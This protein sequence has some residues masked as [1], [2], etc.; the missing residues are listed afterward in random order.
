V[1]ALV[2]LP[3]S[4]YGSVQFSEHLTKQ[5]RE[6]LPRENLRRVEMGEVSYIAHSL[7][8]FIDQYDQSIAKRIVDD[9]SD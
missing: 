2:G 6:R 4:L 1:E 5:I 8:F 3:Y 9:A 7:H